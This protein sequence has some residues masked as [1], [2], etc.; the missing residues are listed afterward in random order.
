[1]RVL[2]D[3]ELEMIS[4]GISDEEAAHLMSVYYGGSWSCSCGGTSS[5]TC[6]Q[7]APSAG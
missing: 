2:E 6:V 5:C 4:G 3:F 7:T 1:M